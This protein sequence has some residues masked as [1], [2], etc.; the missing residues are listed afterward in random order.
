MLKFKNFRGKI[1]EASLKFIIPEDIPV[2][3]RNA[4]MGAAAAA[5]KAG[6]SH[7]D[8]GG[9]KHKVTM[10]GSTARSINSGVTEGYMPSH[11]DEMKKKMM[12]TSD[13]DKLVKI[14]KMLD[15]ESRSRLGKS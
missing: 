3:E 12:T 10:Q 13:K 2:K 11:G 8:F 15:R 5:H 7:F 4:F 9:K 1:Q 14:R 6:K